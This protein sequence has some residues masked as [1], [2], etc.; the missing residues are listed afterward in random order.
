[1]LTFVR[2]S[3][4]NDFDTSKGWGGGLEIKGQISIQLVFGGIITG[5]HILILLGTDV[6]PA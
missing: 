2:R 4:K 6:D 1:M 5:S 3:G